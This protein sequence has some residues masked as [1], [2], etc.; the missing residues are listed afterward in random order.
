MKIQRGGLQPK[1]LWVCSRPVSGE[2][3]GGAVVVKQALDAPIET[4]IH[5]LLVHA[6]AALFR[7]L[8]E[9]HP[10]Q[11]R[12]GAVLAHTRIYVVCLPRIRPLVKLGRGCLP[13]ARDTSPAFVLRVPG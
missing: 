11:F 10:V 4:R 3:T 8:L 7:A 5:A 13:G 2:D 6:F 9:C 12:K 1:T